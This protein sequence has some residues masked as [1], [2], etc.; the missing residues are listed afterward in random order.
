MS[1]KWTT[2]LI[3]WTTE[4]TAT[5]ESTRFRR[6]EVTADTTVTVTQTNAAMQKRNALPA[7]EPTKPARLRRVTNVQA[8]VAAL[9]EWE[10]GN[11]D[12]SALLQWAPA[13]ESACGC[14]DSGPLFTSTVTEVVDT[15]VCFLTTLFIHT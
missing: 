1:E 14:L 7:P 3:R 15:I 4:V 5:I 10:A 2:D 13:V 6:I 8:A 9:Q 12:P 11:I